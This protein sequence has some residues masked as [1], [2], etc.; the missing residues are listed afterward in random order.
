MCQKALAEL[1]GYVIEAALTFGIVA[2]MLESVFPITVVGTL[3][4][5]FAEVFDKALA[6]FG[7][8]DEAEVLVDDGLYA[9]TAYQLGILQHTLVVL[10]L[11]FLFRVSIDI[12]TEV[13]ASAQFSGS[14][15]SYSR[16]KVKIE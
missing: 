3:V 9:L 16:I 2:E 6:P 4:H 13:F 7:M 15:I 12:D 14:R 5:R 1:H 10:H 11:E 8:V